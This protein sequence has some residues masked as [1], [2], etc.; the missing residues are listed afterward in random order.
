[1]SGW[2]SSLIT[3]YS[4]LRLPSFIRFNHVFNLRRLLRHEGL[5]V[6]R[7]DQR[8]EMLA[9]RLDHVDELLRGD[10]RRRLLRIRV[11]EL[12]LERGDS[13]HLRLPRRADI[14]HEARRPHVVLEVVD[15]RLR[16]MRGEFGL[17]RA[18]AGVER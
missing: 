16:T 8:T 2:D 7:A 4:S 14:H 10:E 3:L 11:V 18:Q 6:L 1:M 17:Q 15:D 9:T 12:R 13:A 5:A